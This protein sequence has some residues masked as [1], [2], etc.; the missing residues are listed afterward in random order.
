M[1]AEDLTRWASEDLLNVMIVIAP[2]PEDKIQAREGLL[3]LLTRPI[4]S[5]AVESLLETIVKLAPTPEEMRQTRRALSRL[6]ADQTD[7]KVTAQLMNAMI[8][9][10]PIVRDLSNWQAWAS[11]P[12]HQLLAA[13][14]R[15]STFTDWLAFVPLLP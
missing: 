7:H 12:T 5:F 1:L 8:Y 3:Q 9:F 10:D 6:L 2:T 11:P 13:A 15:N 4:S 14:R